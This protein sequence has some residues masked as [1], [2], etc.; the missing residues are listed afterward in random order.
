MEKRLLKAPWFWAL[1]VNNTWPQ[2]Q[3]SSVSDSHA[4]HML[5]GLTEQNTRPLPFVFL[6]SLCVCLVRKCSVWD[7]WA[8]LMYSTAIY[9]HCAI[10][11][12]NYDYGRGGTQWLTLFSLS[13]S[14]SP[15][16]SLCD[17]SFYRSLFESVSLSLPLF[18]CLCHYHLLSSLLSQS[19]SQGD[20]S[21]VLL[22]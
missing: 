17:F 3:C 9:I 22:P 18:V 21:V 6:S 1:T 4:L 10:F 2:R 12:P 5:T 20:P 14:F 19:V 16:R 8:A 13:I 15:V 11:L 7:R